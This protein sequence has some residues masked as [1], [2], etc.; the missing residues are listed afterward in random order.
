MITVTSSN[1]HYLF[2]AIYTIYFSSNCLKM[3]SFQNKNQLFFIAIKTKKTTMTILTTFAILMSA[4]LISCHPCYN[5]KIIDSGGLAD[6]NWNIFYRFSRNENR[7][8]QEGSKQ[9]I[10]C[11]FG[12]RSQFSLVLHVP[13]QVENVARFDARCDHGCY[14]SHLYFSHRDTS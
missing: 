7:N 11:S 14:L 10:Q 3:N 8:I 2:K 4:G 1:N 13:L 12:I 6:F 9:V 5:N